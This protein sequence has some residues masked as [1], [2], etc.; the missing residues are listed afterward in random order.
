MSEEQQKY[1][2]KSER[3]SFKCTKNFGVC[4]TPQR[5][6][7]EKLTSILISNSAVTIISFMRCEF[8]NGDNPNAVL[9]AC[10]V[11]VRKR[12]I[13]EILNGIRTAPVNT[14]KTVTLENKDV[15]QDRAHTHVNSL[16]NRSD[17][18]M[19]L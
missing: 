6:G 9:F 18:E 7:K 16:A 2:R 4:I 1:V 8:S 19:S 15:T 17:V 11:I 13:S 3:Y 14:V 12:S 5:V 10:F